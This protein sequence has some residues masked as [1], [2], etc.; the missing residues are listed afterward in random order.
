MLKLS[1]VRNATSVAIA[2][3]EVSTMNVTGTVSHGR[4]CAPYV[5]R[6]ETRRVNPRNSEWRC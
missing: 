1:V 4:Q 2:A 3:S 6:P 5:T